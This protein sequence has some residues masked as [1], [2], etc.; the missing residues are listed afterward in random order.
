MTPDPAAETP[1]QPLR[2]LRL[3]R[4]GN[5]R[6]SRGNLRLSCGNLRPRRL[7]TVCIGC[8]P[9]RPQET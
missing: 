9:C 4:C 6:L 2:N 7:L 8:N 1:T 5:L 3:S